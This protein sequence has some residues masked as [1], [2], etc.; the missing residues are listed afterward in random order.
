MESLAAVERL[1]ALAHE[2]RLSIFRLLV[3]VGPQGVNAG[4][5]AQQLNIALPTL[6]FHLSHLSRVGLIKGRQESR[7]IFYAADYAAMNELLAYL[8]DNCCQGNQI[9][10]VQ[11]RSR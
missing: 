7:F 11:R 3:Q 4:A 2:T 6:S 9:V 1:C 8:T 10:H 5:I